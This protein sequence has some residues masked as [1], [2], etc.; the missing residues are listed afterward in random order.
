MK[1][2]FYKR[3][4]AQVS[5][6]TLLAI[7]FIS[8]SALAQRPRNVPQPEDS[9]PL[10]LD[11]LPQILIYIGLPVLFFLLYLWLRRKK[12]KNKN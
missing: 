10:S 8:A 12:S 9:E 11:T 5:I 7:L 6:F 4:A 3:P 1:I 2:L